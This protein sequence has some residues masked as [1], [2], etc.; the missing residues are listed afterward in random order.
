LKRKLWGQIG[1]EGGEW[2]PAGGDTFFY[3][4]DLGTSTFS[5]DAQGRVTGF[6][7][8]SCGGQEI[9]VKKIK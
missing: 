9:H 6:T 1:A 4:D 8:R 3:R 5:R 7:S 2:L